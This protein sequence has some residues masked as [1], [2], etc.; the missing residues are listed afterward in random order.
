SQRPVAKIEE[1]REV[2]AV[3]PKPEAPAPVK[4]AEPVAQPQPAHVAPRLARADAMPAMAQF[5][6]PAEAAPVASESA[7]VLAATALS[8]Q[9]RPGSGEPI[10]PVKVKTITVKAGNVQTAM[11]VPLTAPAPQASVAPPP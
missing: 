2:A 4:V 11:L 10:N 7:T 6:A 3:Q 5:V 9:P 1:S 8:R